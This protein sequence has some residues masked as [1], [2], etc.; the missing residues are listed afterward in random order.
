MKEFYELIEPLGGNQDAVTQYMQIVGKIP[1]DTHESGI[2]ECE[3]GTFP[4]FGKSLVLVAACRRQ[5]GTGGGLFW[6]SSMKQ[7]ER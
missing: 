2:R 7:V 3:T 6:I 1:T 5:E 4:T